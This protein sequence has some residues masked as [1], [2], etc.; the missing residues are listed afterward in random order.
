MVQIRGPIYTSTQHVSGPW[1]GVDEAPELIENTIPVRVED[2]PVLS[3]LK[4][5]PFSRCP[6]IN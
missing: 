2:I 3:G 1:V 4:L 5:I 6:L